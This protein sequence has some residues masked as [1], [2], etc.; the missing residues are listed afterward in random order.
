METQQPDQYTR[1]TDALPRA[2]ARLDR[3]IESAQADADHLSN[4]RLAA[5]LGGVPAALLL[6]VL[7]HLTLLWIGLL[8]TITVFGGLVV[9]HTRA[10]AGI[11]RLRLWR[12]IKAAEL[13]RRA[14]ERAALP[15]PPPD[16]PGRNDPLS[17]DLDL[18]ALH[19]LYDTAASRAG[20]ERLMAW[21]LTPAS[22]D[23]AKTRQTLVRELAANRRYRDRLMLAGLISRAE[24]EGRID[25]A[26][27]LDWLESDSNPAALRVPLF[28]LG[29]LALTT[30]TLFV[31]ASLGMIGPLWAASLGLYVLFYVTQGP[32][33][34]DIFS[35]AM[36]LVDGL[37]ALEAVTTHI[38][39]A[40]YRGMP[41]VEALTAPLRAA[42]PRR[43]L[44]RASRVA[45]GAA[46]RGNPYV[47]L[48]LNTLIPWDMWIAYRLAALRL[49]LTEPLP[50]WMD[51]WANLEALSSLAAAADRDPVSCFPVLSD[52]ADGPLLSVEALGHPLIPFARRVRN[53]LTLVAPGDLVIITGSNMAGKSTFLRTVGIA[54]ALAYAGGPV[55]AARAGIA[56]LRPFTAIRITDS[57]EDG[58]SYF[59]A[60]VR[61]LRALLDA[62]EADD[63]RPLLF[64]VD[65]I[66]RGTN[67]RERL[68][69]ARAYLDALAASNGTGLVATHDLELTSLAD[70]YPS[71][72]NRH[73][74]EEVRDGLMQFEYRLRPGPCP[75]TNALI[76][77]REAGLPVE[78]PEDAH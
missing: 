6:G 50:A 36:T 65:E 49:E 72:R 56:P 3:L 32:R 20:S 78:V 18:D 59:Y 16:L 77:M 14:G 33:I 57:L 26:A 74:R 73:F 37:R 35:D 46:L 45:G 52:G 13:S 28:V 4:W 30:V 55:S 44:S 42:G 70:E 38:E 54:L 31:L 22:L 1:A 10:E 63:P 40:S 19:H 8:L 51:L 9:A 68:A 69:G 66:F 71:V 25:G 17:V 24:D 5:L 27:L 29:M 48:V 15:P 62:L 53:D 58:I 11:R 60:E 21:L 2:I 47:W 12:V 75:T 7:V 67:N 34:G 61:R 76:I 41:T 23:E 43:V 39:T 64:L